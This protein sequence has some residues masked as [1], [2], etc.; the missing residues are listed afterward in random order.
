MTL[1]ITSGDAPIIG[2][3][4]IGYADL[5]LLHGEPEQA[6]ALLGASAAIIG[7]ADRSV[8]DLPRIEAAAQR[9]LGAEGYAAARAR[10]SAYTMNNIVE[11]TRRGA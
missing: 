3:V 6:A 11:L 2:M 1:A 7:M 4:L 9:L 5:A 8:L 10:G